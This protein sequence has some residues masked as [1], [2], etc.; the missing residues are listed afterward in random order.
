MQIDACQSKWTVDDGGWSITPTW[1]VDHGGWWITQDC[2]LW[3]N[4]IFKSGDYG[5]LDSVIKGKIHLDPCV[6]AS[7]EAW[8]L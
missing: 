4:A 3:H 1:F 8:Q 6:A 7:K 2:R 5:F